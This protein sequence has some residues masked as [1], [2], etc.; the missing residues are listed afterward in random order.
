MKKT[1]RFLQMSLCALSLSLA[2]LSPVT[3]RAEEETG[4]GDIDGDP[5]V[6][7]TELSAREVSPEEKESDG[8]T[9]MTPAQELEMVKVI[10]ELEKPGVLEAGLTPG[11]AEAKRYEAQLVNSQNT[12]SASV[13]QS[14][15]QTM[16]LKPVSDDSKAIEHFT[17][18]INAFTMRI[19]KGMKKRISSMHGVKRVFEPQTYNAPETVETDSYEISVAKAAE[20]IGAGSSYTGEYTGKGM[21]IGIADTGLD[22][23]H[24]A[25]D[26]QTAL[27]TCFL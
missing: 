12:M 13:K 23:N 11:S 25:F 8:L 18:V 24:S 17:N 26:I 21:L 5:I 16:A 14:V 2:G 15:N 27:D 1:F 6:S 4:L 7:V 20:L 22:L 9:P 10:V 3:V 19:P